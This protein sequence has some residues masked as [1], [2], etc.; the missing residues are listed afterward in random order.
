MNYFSTCNTVVR[1]HFPVRGKSIQL[2]AKRSHAAFT[3]VE[4]LVVITIIGVLLTVGALGLRNLSKSSGVSAGV[5]LAEA[6]FAEARGLSSGTGGASRVLIAAD[7]DDNDRYLRY[8]LVVYQSESGRWVAASRGIYLPK[9]VYLSQNFSYLDHAGETGGIPSE[10]HQV[11][12]SDTGGSSNTNLSG[13]YF[14]YQFNSEGNAANPG[15]SF[16]VGTGNKPPGASNPKVG[17]GSGVANFGGFMVWKKGTTSIFR[18]PDQMN[19]PSE[20]KGGEDF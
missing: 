17:S 7:P 8:M 12:S 13:A 11:Y 18:H 5:P 10:N 6:V 14:Y 20:I 3:L 15:A 1:A 4:M 16:I 19:I 2:H 9:G